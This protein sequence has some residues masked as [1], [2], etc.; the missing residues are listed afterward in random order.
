MVGSAEYECTT[1]AIIFVTHKNIIS[2]LWWLLLLLESLP[3]L[4]VRIVALSQNGI[5][6]KCPNCQNLMATSTNA[7]VNIVI[8]GKPK[9]VK[10]SLHYEPSLNDLSDVRLSF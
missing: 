3:K 9:E 1:L 8:K 10:P 6:E 7:L 2:L 5:K 4:A